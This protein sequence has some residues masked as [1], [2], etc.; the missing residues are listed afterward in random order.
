MLLNLELEGNVRLWD[1]TGMAESNFTHLS[2]GDGLLY[3][4]V[5]CWA[6]CVPPDALLYF[7]ELSQETCLLSL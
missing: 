3:Q 7:G 6:S 2:S 1:L 4:Q 5:K